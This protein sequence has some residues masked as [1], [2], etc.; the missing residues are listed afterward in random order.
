L[1]V[2]DE[3]DRSSG[4]LPEIMDDEMVLRGFSKATREAYSGN[5]RRFLR[6][7]LPL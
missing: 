7:G 4:D 5:V 2:L 1:Y 6:S 3:H